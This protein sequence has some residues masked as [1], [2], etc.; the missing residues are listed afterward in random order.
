MNYGALALEMGG[1]R[2]TPRPYAGT[3][4]ETGRVAGIA[5]GGWRQR[6]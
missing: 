3:G 6:D 1:G 2:G 5:A 4:V